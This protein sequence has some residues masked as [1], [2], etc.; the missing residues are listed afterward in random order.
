MLT[1]Y[2]RAFMT[3]TPIGSISWAYILALSLIVMT[4]LITWL[5]LRFSDSRLAPLADRVDREER[6]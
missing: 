3:R 1:A 2:A 4:W 5:Y 6:R